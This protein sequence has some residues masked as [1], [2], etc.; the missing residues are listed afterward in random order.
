MSDP[1]VRTIVETEEGELAFQE[2]FVHRRCEPRV[3]GFSFD[4]AEEAEPASGAREALQAADAVVI[5]P[6]NPWVSI[7]PILQCHPKRLKNLFLQFPPSSAE[8]QSKVPRQR[9]IANW[10][11][12]LPH[13]RWQTII[14][15]VATDFV[16]DEVDKQLKGDIIGLDMRYACNEYA[17]EKS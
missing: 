14:V 13:W 10:E 12:N 7:D 15:D 17:D 1:P 16:L 2:Y 3:K 8:K 9:C 11:S 5:C 4:G 6:S